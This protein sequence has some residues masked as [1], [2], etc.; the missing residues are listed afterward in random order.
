MTLPVRELKCE[1]VEETERDFRPGEL[2]E[3]GGK[4]VCWQCGQPGSLERG[5]CLTLPDGETM[6]REAY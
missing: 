4:L 3:K 1:P 6:C 2:I 5:Y